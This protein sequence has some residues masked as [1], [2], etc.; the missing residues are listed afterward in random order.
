MNE[1]KWS[2]AEKAIARQA[3]SR[4]LDEELRELIQLAKERAVRIDKAEEL[5][6]LESW[7]KER[8]LEINLQYDYRYSFL[9]GVFSSLLARGR[10]SRRNL[11]GL[12]P[13]KVEILVRS[14]SIL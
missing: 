12:A 4:A 11:E 3:F 8:R 6:E 14:A 1:W 5:W 13:E 2:P 10:I 9:P 7:L